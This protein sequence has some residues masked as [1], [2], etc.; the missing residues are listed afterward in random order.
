MSAAKVFA[1][2][3]QEVETI[4]LARW[5]AL[6][7]GVL[8]AEGVAQGEL[9]LAFVDEPDMAELNEEHMGES[10][11]TDV[12]SFPIDAD[13]AVGAPAEH[14][15]D[16]EPLLLGDVIVCPSVAAANA[17]AHAGTVDDELALLVVHGVL[18]V[19]GHDHASPEDTTRMQAR[20]L[21][22]LMQLHW[23]GA[24]PATFVAHRS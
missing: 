24:A 7:E 12:L 11:A 19:L 21:H 3:E 10:Y 22:H 6:A 13:A 9:T 16:G 5:A 14:D 17:P 15:P 2:D 8:A 23:R 20:E 1:Y 4:D 18:H